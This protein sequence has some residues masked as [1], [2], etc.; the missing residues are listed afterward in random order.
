MAR[1]DTARR[2]I[3]NADD[4]GAS[5]GINAAVIQAHRDGI[6]TTASLMVNE[7][8]F[9]E[10]LA[11]AR[12]NPRLGVGLHLT[13][14]HGHSALP[15]ERIP[16]LVNARGEF[17]NSPA[18]T[19]LR[20]F[21]RRELRGQLRAE[22]KAQFET[23]RLAGLPLDH[24]NGHLHFHLHPTIFGIVMQLAEEY[25]V[26]RMR[27]THDPFWLNA[28]LMSGQWVYRAT[29]AFIY[30]CLTARARGGLKRCG[31][32]HTAH[33][34]GLMRHGRVDEDYILRLLPRLPAGD[35]ELYSHPSLDEFKHEL[36]A[37]ISPRV[38][39]AVQ[40]QGIQLIRY[41]DL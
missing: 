26:Q 15:P 21:T 22:I 7:P 29:H 12:Q 35:S 31:I 20:Y 3:I 28:R 30:R 14:S 18:A 10:A 23:F 40:A 16:G 39:A 36:D 8:A 13:L 33:V 38:E 27:L 17:S 24:V 37:L 41:Q 6:L 1:L 19:G 11:L 34:F 25:G 9:P 4:F 2:L 32:R 5:P